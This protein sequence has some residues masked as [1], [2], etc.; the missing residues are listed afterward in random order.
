MSFFAET[1]PAS[2]PGSVFALSYGDADVTRFVSSRDKLARELGCSLRLVAFMLNEP[3]NPG[4]TQNGSYDVRKW[5]T[6]FAN[7]KKENEGEDGEPGRELDLGKNTK[8]ELAQ[9]K[10][11][12]L[13]A[14]AEIAE[15]NAAQRRGELIDLAAVQKAAREFSVRLRAF[16]HREMTIEAVSELT[17]RLCLENAQVGALV[18]FM[19]DFHIRFCRKIAA[20]NEKD[21]AQN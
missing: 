15:L 20:W 5:K 1:E 9:A 10:L 18:E 4:S 19:E 17:V 11:R 8:A 16:H 3:G 2:Q 7:R 13:R 6:Y 21:I 12:E 14:K